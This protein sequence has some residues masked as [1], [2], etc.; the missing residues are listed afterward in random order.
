MGEAAWER[1][2]QQRRWP[3]WRTASAQ[4][5]VSRADVA[6][7]ARFLPEILSPE[8]DVSATVALK[9]GGDISGEIALHNGRTRPLD[10]VGPIRDI[11]A[12]LLL[13]GPVLELADLSGSLGGQR[14]AVSG[15]ARL[16]DP[17]WDFKR[18][19]QFQVRLVGT[20]VPL[21]R[22]PDVVLRADL[23]LSVTNGAA[24]PAQVGGTVRLRDS[25]YL[26]DL[27][28]LTSGGVTTPARRPPFFSIDLMPW[29]EWQLNVQVHGERF[30]QVRSPL[31]RGIISTTLKLEGTL[32]DPIAL[33]EARIN[34]GAVTFPF[35]SL[36]VQQGFVSLTSDDPY[37]PRLLV[38]ASAE[39][40][41]YDIKMEAT[42]PAEDPVVQFSSS[43]P[44]SSEEI[45]LMLTTGQRP[46][47]LAA[48][49]TQQRAQGLALFVGKN[50]LTDLGFGG[51]GEQRLSIRSGEHLTETGR[52]TYEVEYRFTDD[53]SL[54]GEYDRFGQ[55]NLGLKWRVYSR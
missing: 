14:V 50:I 44:L 51:A 6:P 9:P 46:R 37:R 28:D 20:N 21:A 48:L 27:R 13:A 29:A 43:P 1:L 22:K 16:N 32:K 17:P 23:D 39:R 45:L 12:R 3:D 54:L 15:K 5:E 40:L 24:A 52:S 35:G 49:S 4:I 33:G 10:G 30:L 2:I 26:S 19:P 41:G 31:F 55:Y 42:G 7:F 36:D 34:S 38:N 25:F 11:E 47:E 8:G 18:I 53:W